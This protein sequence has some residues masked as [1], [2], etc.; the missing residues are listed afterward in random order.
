MMLDIIWPFSSSMT[1]LRPL[2]ASNPSYPSAI[3][4]RVIWSFNNGQGTSAEDSQS[5]TACLH[6]S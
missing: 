6:P 3:Y 5:G 1:N 2:N 4:S